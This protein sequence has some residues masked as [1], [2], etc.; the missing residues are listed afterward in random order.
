MSI[1]TDD[2]LLAILD[3]YG[4]M[5]LNWPEDEREAAKS[6]LDASPERFAEA[7][8]NAQTLDDQ[9]L[10]LPTVDL[11]SGLIENVLA[12]APMGEPVK[13]A[14]EL[15]WRLR[16]WASGLAT[17]CLSLGLAVGYAMPLNTSDGYDPS[18]EAL[19]YA[20]FSDDLSSW[21]FESDG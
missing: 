9:L 10:R 3:A 7:L 6:L 14:S 17:A 1:M 21:G 20:F 18:E 11:P 5:P 19:T 2:R 15:G 16:I 4:A 8:A 13:P 12:E